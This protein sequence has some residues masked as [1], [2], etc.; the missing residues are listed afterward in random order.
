MSVKI[1]A[2]VWEYSQHSGSALLCLLAIA[3][4]ANDDGVAYPGASRLAKRARVK[5]RH[6]FKLLDRLIDSGELIAFNRAADEGGFTSNAYTVISGCSEEEIKRRV[7]KMR[8]DIRGIINWGTVPPTVPQNTTPTVPQ[9]TTLVSQGTHETSIETSIEPTTSGDEDKK[10]QRPRNLLFDKIALR[11][12]GVSD[13][14]K[15]PKSS[16]GWISGI[17]A[18]IKK[19][20]EGVTPEKLDEFY[21]W[22]KAEY[23]DCTTVKERGKFSLHYAAFLAN[24]EKHR[25]PASQRQLVDQDNPR[26]PRHYE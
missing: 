23:P 6:V 17:V 25:K 20:D 12:F 3:D 26:A 11:S 8:R 10:I 22:D 4:H 13:T 24:P 21:S 19:L 2:E 9:N 15:L 18:D 1:M 5:K 14:T 16:A 7:G